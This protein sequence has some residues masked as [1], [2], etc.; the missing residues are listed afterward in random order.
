MAGVLH[1]QSLGGDSKLM[2]VGSASRDESD[3]M[4]TNSLTR[5]AKVPTGLGNAWVDDVS[6][7][8]DLGF[9]IVEKWP[10]E[11]SEDHLLAIPRHTSFSI[12]ASGQ[13]LQ[14]R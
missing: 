11:Y 1:I 13:R 9:T 2:H 7:T 4:F 12:G 14:A 3:K 6:H 5:P 10:S 8:S